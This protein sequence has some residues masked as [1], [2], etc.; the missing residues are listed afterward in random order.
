MVLPKE[1]NWFLVKFRVIRE[2]FRDAFICV[3][4]SEELGN[5]TGLYWLLITKDVGLFSSNNYFDPN[6]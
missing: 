3:F 4:Y 5:S 1:L 6:W 2:A